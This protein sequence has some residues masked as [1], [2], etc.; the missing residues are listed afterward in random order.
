[1]NRVVIPPSGQAAA[2]RH[3]GSESAIFFLQVA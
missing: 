1:M 2:H 3:M